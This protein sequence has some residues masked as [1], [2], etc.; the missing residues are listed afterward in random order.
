MNH[1]PDDVAQ[2]VLDVAR[3]GYL[4]LAR[5]RVEIQVHAERGFCGPLAIERSF[6]DPAGRS[7]ALH[8]QLGV[9][10]AA[11]NL[12]RRREHASSRGSSRHNDTLRS[13]SLYT[14][15]ALLTAY[16]RGCEKSGTLRGWLANAGVQR[17]VEFVFMGTPLAYA[18]T[19]IE[20]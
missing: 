20:I 18:H 13:V 3:I 7:H 9:A 5:R 8:R 19:A 1:G 10:P 11:E 4:E 12:A 16:L 17:L 6:R 15:I 14:R 2:I